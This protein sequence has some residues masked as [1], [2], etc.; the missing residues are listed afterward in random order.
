[1][2]FI[3]M[4]NLTVSPGKFSEIKLFKFRS[5]AKAQSQ[6]LYLAFLIA[7]GIAV[8]KMS[9]AH[10]QVLLE[11][12]VIKQSIEGNTAELIGQQ[13]S[14]FVFY[15]PDGTMRM[16]NRALGPDEGVWRVSS[17]GDF[18]GKWK[19]LRNNVEACAPMIDIG[20]GIYQWGNVKLRILLGNPKG[21]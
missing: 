11:A 6:K 16:L 20:G 5:G 12:N 4:N 1:M 7:M 9:D 15:A 19:K 18:C 17:E 13:N 3:I 14:S 2:D 8:A 10:A 21:L